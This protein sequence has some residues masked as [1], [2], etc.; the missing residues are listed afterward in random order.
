[1][2][3]GRNIDV[4]TAKPKPLKQRLTKQEE[5]ALGNLDMWESIV[6]KADM[7][8]CLGKMTSIYLLGNRTY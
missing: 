2:L 5:T 7:I 3:R 4:N 1:M 8:T 6:V